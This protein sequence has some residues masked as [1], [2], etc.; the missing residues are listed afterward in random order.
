VLLLLLLL[1]SLPPP[2]LLLLLARA[3]AFKGGLFS[4]FGSNPLSSR[5]SFGLLLIRHVGTP[6][7]LHSR[8]A[9]P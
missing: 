8:P 7:F 5:T 9:S 3:A 6:G 1:L 4:P 2:P